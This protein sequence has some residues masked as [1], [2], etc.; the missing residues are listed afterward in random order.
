[1]YNITDIDNIVKYCQE[2]HVDGVVAGFLDPCQMPYAQICQ[3]LNLPCTGTPEQFFTFTNKIAF[4]E[5]CRKMGL[6]LFLIIQL[7]M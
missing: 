6:M 3:K 1:M 4:K 2:N 7:M 5:L